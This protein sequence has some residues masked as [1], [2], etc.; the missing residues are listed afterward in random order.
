MTNQSLRVV[1]WLGALAVGSILVVQA[2]WMVY[3]WNTEEQKLNQRIFVALKNV[4]EALADY[5]RSTLTQEHPVQQLDSDYYVVRVDDAI[6]INVLEHYLRTELTQGDVLLPFEYVVYDCQDDRMVFGNRVNLLHQRVSTVAPRPLPTYDEYT[7][8]FGVVFPDKSQALLGYMQPWLVLSG[9]LLVIV[10]FFC[11]AL[12]AMLRQKRLSELQKDFISNMTHEFKTPL[13]TINVS[14]DVLMSGS[15][16]LSEER[17]TRYA[18]LV[19]EQTLRLNRQVERVLQIAQVEQGRLSLQK[20]SVDLHQIVDC[21][22]ASFSARHPHGLHL[23][24][25]FQATSPIIAGDEFHLTNVLHNLI[26]NAIKY[27]VTMANV[28]VSTYQSHQELLLQVADQ[29]VGISNVFIKK[30]FKKFFRV[31]TGNIH[32]VRGFGLGLYYAQQVCHL[33]RW[34]IEVESTLHQGSVFTIKI[35]L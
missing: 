31:P 4:S 14:A 28:R 3:T 23:T 25:N 18:T 5:N 32:N 21:V 29:G 34:S 24:V 27:S 6:N 20:K 7:Y 10:V 30:V 17:R 1:T 19:K 11:Y 26:D 2:Y 15:D 16:E 12:T 8:Y 22:V 35:P 13:A 9:G 33:H